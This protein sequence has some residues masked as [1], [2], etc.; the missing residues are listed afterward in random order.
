MDIK[1]WGCRGSQTTPLTNAEIES[2]IKKVLERASSADIASEEAIDGFL[3]SLPFSMKHTYGGNTT[4]ITVSAG[5]RRLIIDC[6]SGF[7]NLG[8]TL[9][10]GDFSKGRGAVDI[11]MTH[12]HL[13]HI[14]GIP[15]FEPLYIKGNR[16]T[17]YSPVKDLHDRLASQQKSAFFPIPLDSMASEKVFKHVNCDE[18]FFIDDFKISSK[19]MPHPG[20]SYG[21]RIEYNG[22]AF[23]YTG[24]C[25]FNMA[26]LEKI[27]DYRK[28]FSNAELLIFDTQY[29]FD[30]SIKKVNWG[31]S[32]AFMALDIAAMFGVKHVI[33]FHHNPAYNDAKLDEILGDAISYQKTHV[34][35]Q[36]TVVELAYDGLEISI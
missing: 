8:K 17:F 13:D 26:E 11:L 12:T 18:D 2:K 4:C 20:G 27:G 3:K 35:L 19:E 10:A 21:Y 29:T 33:L 6:G 16:F 31:H 14:K 5:G 7:A 28:F 1:I 36:N 15:F 23:V 22:K 34:K 24:D 30:E 25:E 9:M 32:T